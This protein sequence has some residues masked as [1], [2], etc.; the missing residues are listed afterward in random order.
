MHH[1]PPCY[2]LRFHETWGSGP[3]PSSF[4]CYSVPWCCAKSSVSKKPVSR[5]FV[6]LAIIWVFL[7]LLFLIC[8]ARETE[9]PLK[10]Y[11]YDS[12]KSSCTFYFIFY[13]GRNSSYSLQV[14]AKIICSLYQVLSLDRCCVCGRETDRH[15]QA[16]WKTD[17]LTGLSSF[18][19]SETRDYSELPWRNIWGEKLSP[20]I[21][22]TPIS[23]CIYWGITSWK[24][25]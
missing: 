3:H 11:I 14:L 10:F 4:S 20:S 6:T 19:V 5:P 15:R 25:V 12:A 13:W 18:W 16:G 17:R 9:L 7:C 2:N 23:S 1:H 21:W 8:A 24:H 22:P